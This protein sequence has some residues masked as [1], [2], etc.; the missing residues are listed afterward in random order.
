VQIRVL[1]KKNV[2]TN[3]SKCVQDC[4]AL[5]PLSNKTTIRT[6]KNMKSHVAKKGQGQQVS[7]CEESSCRKSNKNKKRAIHWVCRL[8]RSRRA[9][10]E[11]KGK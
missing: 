3:L 4:L 11:R 5:F 2:N 7:M 6:S 8:D 9:E 1:N 10:K